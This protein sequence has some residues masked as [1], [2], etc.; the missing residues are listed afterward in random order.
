MS[1]IQIDRSRAPIPGD[2]RPFTFPEIQ[3]HR[4]RNGL[5]LFFAPTAGAEVATMS[6][7]MPGGARRE[8]ESDAG[9]AKLTSLLIESGTADLGAA[10][11]S[12]RLESMGVDLD[13]GCGWDV[14]HA[15]FTALSDKVADA[16]ELMA[17]L[18]R[19]PSFPAEEFERLKDQQLATIVQRRAQP[20]SFANEL[21]KRFIFADESVYARPISGRA[22][23]VQGIEPSDVRS[24][25]DRF[26]TP[27]GGAII[28]SGNIDSD[29]LVDIAEQAFGDWT[30]PTLKPSPPCAAAR[31]QTTSVI[32]VNRPGAVQSEI[33]IGHIGAARDTTDYFAILVM[34]TILGGA[35]S[36]RLNLNLRERNGFTYGVRSRFAMRREPGPFL[37]STAV[38]TEVTAPAVREIYNELHAIRDKAVAQSELND[39]RQ[40]VAGTFPLRLQ[41][42]DDI[43]ARL[44]E[45]FIY[46]LPDRYLEEFP[47]RILDVTED[48]VKRAAHTYVRPSRAIAVVLGDAE[49]VVPELEALDLAPVEVVDPESIQ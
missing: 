45:L 12:E 7:L 15:D 48:Q 2:V 11:V 33:R 14:C 30:G 19:S 13:T 34:N 9:L 22:A 25:H 47:Q 16:A 10:E 26:Y 38:Q 44:A 31:Y 27:V 36:S 39:A 40:Y 49:K 23:T 6:I 24:F 32:V 42:T 46:D 8:D 1:T 37:V 43:A 17:R 41:T 4:L 35:F 20:S 29:R 21:A 3:R 5:P 18:V 28:A